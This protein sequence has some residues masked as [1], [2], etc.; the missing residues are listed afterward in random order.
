M[1]CK[2]RERHFRRKSLEPPKGLGGQVFF[3]KKAKQ[4]TKDIHFRPGGWGSKM[5]LQGPEIVVEGMVL[6]R[7]SH[8]HVTASTGVARK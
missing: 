8:S 1:Y 3:S 4:I 2:R 7:F 5:K 6:P